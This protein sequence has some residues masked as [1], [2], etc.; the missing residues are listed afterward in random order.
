[1]PIGAYVDCS[2][3]PTCGLASEHGIIGS[4]DDLQDILMRMRFRG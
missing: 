1:M 3:T 4:L 2:V